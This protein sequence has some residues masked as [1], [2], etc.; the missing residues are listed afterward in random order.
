MFSSAVFASVP[1]APATCMPFGRR[2]CTSRS[3]CSNVFASPR[4]TKLVPLRAASGSA[5]AMAGEMWRSS[6]SLTPWPPFTLS[7]TGLMSV[8]VTA[9]TEAAGCSACICSKPSKVWR[10]VTS[11]TKRI[12][13]AFCVSI[14]PVL[15][16]SERSCEAFAFLYSTSS[17]AVPSSTLMRT[18]RKRSSTDWPNFF[19]KLWKV[20]RIGC[21]AS[22]ASP[23]VIFPVA[24]SCCSSASNR[25]RVGEAPSFLASS[26]MDFAHASSAFFFSSSC[27]WLWPSK[28]VA[29]C[30]ERCSAS[31]GTLPAFSMNSPTGT[32]TRPPRVSASTSFCAPDSPSTCSAAAL[33]SSLVWKNVLKAAASK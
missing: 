9:T 10:S 17:L 25:S 23:F 5:A 13:A 14:L 2:A 16:C 20:S 6:A 19:A 28:L 29:S 7:L 33:A 11:S 22:F 15:S 32:A 26:A 31:P 3:T 21:S 12:S 30:F 24:T 4:M 8:S 27:T 18:L 1:T